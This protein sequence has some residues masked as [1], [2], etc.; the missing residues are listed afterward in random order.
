MSDLVRIEG[1]GG[2]N[3]PFG[4]LGLGAPRR[5]ARSPNI[6]TRIGLLG[7]LILVIDRLAGE[8]QRCVGRGRWQR[9]HGED[10]VCQFL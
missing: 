4:A 1:G 8:R 2:D 9:L 7:C 5:P 10:L 6:G 3:A